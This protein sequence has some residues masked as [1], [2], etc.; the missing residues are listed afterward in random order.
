M[1]TSLLLV[2][3]LAAAAVALAAP[4]T[5]LQYKAKWGSFKHSF[6][7]TYATKHEEQLRFEIFADNL[8]RIM[9]HESN[10]NRTHFLA[11]N[12]FGDLTNEE[13]VARY[14][15]LR[16][17]SS[18]FLRSRNEHSISLKHAMVP[19]AVNW[20]AEGVVTPVKDQGQ[21]GSCWAFSTTGSVEAAYAI[22]QKT[23]PVSLSEQELVDC[24]TAEGNQGCNGG[25]MDYAFEYIISN[26]GLCKESAYTY[27]AKDGTCVKSKCT[28]A[29]TITG[30]KDVPAKDELQLQAAVA[31]QPVSVAVDAQGADWQFYSGG[32]IG[33]GCGTELDHGVLA[34][35]YGTL[36]GTPYWIVK[37]SWGPG[38]GLGGYIL[39]QR[40]T[41]AGSPGACGIALSA[42]YPTGATKV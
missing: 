3:V 39:I 12:Q 41:T 32:V 26:K 21:C 40:G 27:K 11:M 37:N 19:D 1:R 14:T 8:D 18:P 16:P 4:L 33:K 9:R 42:S 20:T 22:A 31:Q 13:F 34:V 7:K 23:T 15:S 35:G 28:S 36:N 38:W 10:P 29:V 17:V 6:T 24:A 30:Y 25:L 5:E 2:C